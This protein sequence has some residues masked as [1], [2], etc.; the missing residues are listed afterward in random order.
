MSIITPKLGIVMEGVE[1]VEGVTATVPPLGMIT[2]VTTA[3]VTMSWM[4][5]AT[6][7]SYLITFNLSHV[8]YHMPR[9]VFSV[10]TYVWNVWRRETMCREVSAL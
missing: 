4:C 3:A 8:T 2:M 1:G 9:L 5:V 7:H 10:A 6:R